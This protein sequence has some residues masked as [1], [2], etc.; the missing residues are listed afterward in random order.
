VLDSIAVKNVRFSVIHFDGKRE[1]EFSL[2]PHQ[3]IECGLVEIQYPRR[4]HDLAL[5]NLKRIIGL[6]DSF[7]IFRKLRVVL[8]FPGFGKIENNAIPAIPADQGSI[9]S[10]QYLLPRT[11]VTPAVRT[12]TDDSARTWIYLLFVVAFFFQSSTP[13]SG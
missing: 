9:Y 12:G 13:V 7:L 3:E 6:H 2:R 10:E 4:L 11:Q 1:L 5:S 8:D